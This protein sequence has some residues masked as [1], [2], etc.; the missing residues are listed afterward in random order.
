[1][2]HAGD[3]GRKGSGSVAGALIYTCAFLLAL[4]LVAVFILVLS[5]WFISWFHTSAPNKGIHSKKSRFGLG[6][7]EPSLEAKGSLI[8]GTAT[9]YCPL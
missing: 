7:S 1:M 5:T 9:E 3:S 8:P 6:L 2:A 4:D